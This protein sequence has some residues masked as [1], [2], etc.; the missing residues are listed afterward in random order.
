MGL[1]AAF[2]VLALAPQDPTPSPSPRP[3]AVLAAQE[4]RGDAADAGVLTQL[5][6]GDD[7][8][9]AARAAWALGRTK[10]PDALTALRTVAKDSRHADARLQAMHALTARADADSQLTAVAGLLDADARVR[11]EAARLAGAT[12]LTA[13]AKALVAMVGIAAKQGAAATAPDVPA[14]LLALC[15]L[16]AAD[17]VL[18]AAQALDGARLG[19]AGPAL[20]YLCQEL[21]PT[22]PRPAQLTTLQS[23][24][25]HSEPEVRR[26]AMTQLASLRDATALPWVQ[27]RIAVEQGDLQTLAQ[28]ACAV[29]GAPP[30]S[31]DPLVQGKR[32]ARAI[33]W[34]AAS[35]WRHSDDTD[36][37]I[38]VGA[39]CALLTLVFVGMVLGRR[40]RA[41]AAAAAAAGHD[42]A[43]YAEG[44]V[45]GEA[46]DE[47][48]AE[49]EAPVDDAADATYADGEVAGDEAYA[50]GDDQAADAT[51]PAYAEVGADDATSDRATADDDSW[52]GDAQPPR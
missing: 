42:E 51:E 18:A 16:R 39:P 19:S 40:R 47:A 34:R 52:T 32:N 45:P 36:K 28:Q 9:V 50:E 11:A 4:E 7:E 49:E 3:A 27:A 33:A 5:A 14:A 43:A 8:A 46:T 10:G 15:D 22:L 2:A 12:K 41:A 26:F 35:W 17:D 23:L 6:Q 25:A 37:A 30:P 44:D 48:Y 29:I 38:V 24:V 13:A 1:L 31:D 20:H 21:V